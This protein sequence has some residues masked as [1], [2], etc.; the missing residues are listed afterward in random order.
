MTKQAVKKQ[1]AALPYRKHGEGIEVL[2]ITSRET[3]RWVIPKGWPMRNLTDRNAAKQEAFEEAGIE[4]KMGKKSMGSFTYSKRMKS[5]RMQ[6][7]QVTVY[8]M[9]VSRLLDKWPEQNQR[10]RRWFAMKEAIERV[11]EEGLRAVIQAALA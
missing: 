7:V 5:G 2:L 3:R 8:A 4:G 10:K 11:N 1:I 6:V 9:E